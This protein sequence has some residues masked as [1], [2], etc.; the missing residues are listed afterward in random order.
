MRG[1]YDNKIPVPGERFSY[2]VTHPENTFD[3]HGRKLMPTK[4]EKMEFANMV[5][6][7]R[8]ELDLYHYFEKTII[9]F[10]ARFIMY[11]KRYEPISSNK[12]MQ[13]EDPDEKYK[14][15]DDYAQN[16]TK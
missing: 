16:K 1:K 15:I 11:E 2:V 7:L 13:I 5:K 14:Q 12:I 10:C 6:E 3:L 8:K 4:D 9:S